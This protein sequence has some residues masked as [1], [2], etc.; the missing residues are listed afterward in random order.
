MHAFLRFTIEFVTWLHIE[1]VVPSIGVH[2]HAIDTFTFQAVFILA[3][4][5]FV[6]AEGA[7]LRI[8][9]IVFGLP[10]MAVGQKETLLLLSQMIAFEALSLQAVGISLECHFHSTQVGDVLTQSVIA[11]VEDTGQFV[12]HHLQ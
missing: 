10:Q 1:E 12:G 4:T 8:K 6:S 2:H 7:L 3:P 9:R 5:K 11:V